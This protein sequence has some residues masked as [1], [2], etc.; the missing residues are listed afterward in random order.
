MPTVRDPTRTSTDPKRKLRVLLSAYACLPDHGSEPGI[1]WDWATRL[2]RAGHEV[3]VLTLS[4]NR[5]G[6]ERKLGGGAIDNV[7]FVY[8]DLPL[9][10]RARNSVPARWM[11]LHYALWQY[12]A[13]GVARRLCREVRFDVVHHLTYGVFRHPS[14]LAFLGIPFV[15][16]PVGGGE[17]AP[18]ALRKTFPLRGYLV[19]LARDLANRAVSVDPLMGAVFR[20][21]R[22]TLCKTGETRARIPARFRAKCAVQVELGTDELAAVQRTPGADGAFRV[23]YVGRLVYWKGLHLGLMAFARLRATHSA[24]VMTVIGRRALPPNMYFIF[25]I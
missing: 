23:L 20:R 8:Y 14:F 1:G 3:W 6:I 9:R 25:A 17:T 10:K 22:L 5:D 21:S 19:D 15:F 24:A 13:Y 7:H 12:G 16:G 2:A 4:F 11:R 18:R